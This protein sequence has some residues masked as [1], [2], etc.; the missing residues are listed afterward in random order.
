MVLVALIGIVGIPA[1]IGGYLL[2]A[3]AALGRL[4]VRGQ[5]ILRPWLWLGP[6]FAFLS[7]FLIYPTLNTVYLSLLS[8]RST[9]FVGLQNYIFAITN[10][11][12][13]AALKNNLLW[14]VIFPAVTVGVGL[15][16][17][18]LT[19]RVRYES[20]VRS[21]LFMPMGISF[22]AASVTWKFVY[23]YRPPG[24]PQIGA[25]NALVSGVVK[26]AHPTAWLVAPTVNNMALIAVGVWVWT[27]F[28]LV[29]LSA[30][31]KAIP[32]E[33]PEA[34]RVDGAN[35]W[36]VFRTITFPALRP[37]VGV[38]VTTMVI[39]ALKAF[40]IV[41]VMTNGNF[42]TEV[43]ATRMYKEMFVFRDFGRAS[44]I[45]VLLF[46]ATLPVVV[47]NIR[48]FREQEALR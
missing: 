22:V 26:H 11:G 9:E 32:G 48:R 36:Q 38:V 21:I 35:E 1:C 47:A 14:L 28:C 37:T 19:D 15:V 30:A 44:A 8:A 46:A 40:D 10:G 13:R 34:A 42:D 17:A 24:D 6:A 27:G 29:V 5:T 4:S 31:L 12:M 41:Y 20:L 43:I 33:L 7:A 16:V 39:F 18:V 2:F 3:E 25:L 45:A 23:A